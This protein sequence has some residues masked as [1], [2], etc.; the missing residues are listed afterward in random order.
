MNAENQGHWA[1]ES[2]GIGERATA[3]EGRVSSRELEEQLRLADE[4]SH[5]QKPV[6]LDVR[7]PAEYSIAALPGS[8]SES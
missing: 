5:S 4:A 6:L 7:S 8:I 2:C 1:I 3:E